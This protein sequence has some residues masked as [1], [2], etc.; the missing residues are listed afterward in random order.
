MEKIGESTKDKGGKYYPINKAED[1]KQIIPMIY[2]GIKESFV[3]TYWSCSKEKDTVVLSL[4]VKKDKSTNF[5]DDIKY[6]P[7]EKTQDPSI[8][9]CKKREIIIGIIAIGIIIIALA[10]FLILNMIKKRKYRIEKDEEK[11]LRE[12][13]SRENQ[14]RY[15]ELYNQ[16]QETINSFESQ[17][18]VSQ[19]DKEKIMKLEERLSTASKTLP[20]IAVKPIDTR[21]RTM[22]LTKT[23]GAVPPAG[24]SLLVR[25]GRQAGQ[26]VTISEFGIL[27]GRTEGGLLLQ[28]DTV[29]R[30]H[31]RIF[32]SEGKFIIEDLNATNG[33]FVNGKRINQSVIYPNDIIRIGSIELLFNN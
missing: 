4:E 7:K 21:R 13:D 10:V 22:I 11:M 29:S 14:R 27:I 15:D 24:A 18:Y 12:Q 2:T 23:Q 16:Y 3:L 5:R 30:K 33:T 19:A 6:Y 20:G 8:W 26:K 31:A 1:I 9:T 25:N 28:D 32:L 17:K